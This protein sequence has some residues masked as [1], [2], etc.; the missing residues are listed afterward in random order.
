MQNVNNINT[1]VTSGKGMIKDL[2]D[3]Y[4]GKDVLSHARNAVLNSHQGD[5]FVYGNE[6]SNLECW[7]FPYQFNGS[8]P[9]K[10]K[11]HLIFTTDNTNSEIGIAS[12]LDCSYKTLMND[13]CLNFNLDY[14][15]IGRS[16]E[17]D[18]CS[19]V[20]TFVNNWNPIRRLDI[21]KIPYKYTVADDDCKT[22][23]YTKD[24]DCDS[25]NLFRNISIPKVK[26][27]KTAAGE[28]PNG[29][30]QFL[31][32][33]AIAD[34]KYSDYYA[35]TKPLAIF[36]QSGIGGGMT[37]NISNLDLDF[38]QYELV[39][40]STNKG[41]ST[42]RQVGFFSTSQ[43]TVTITNN[44]FPIEIPLGNLVITKKNY[45]KA[46][47]ISGNSQYLM[48]ADLTQK[49]RLN[50]QLQAFDITSEY[51][52]EQHLADYYKEEGENVGLWR[53]EVYSYWIRFLYPDGSYS[54][55]F[56]IPGR[57]VLSDEKSTVSG[58][59]IF[60]FDS[61]TG[62][63]KPKQVYKYEAYNTAQKMI[64]QN[65]DFVNNSREYGRGF[66]AYHESTE[67][68]PDNKLMFGEDACTPIRH[69]RMPDE[70][71][72]PRYSN[73]KGV[74]YI[75]VLGIR[76]KNIPHPLDENGNPANV[77]GYM[78]LR[79]DRSGG[80]KT[81]EGRGLLTNMRGYTDVSA[82][83]ADDAVEVMYSNYPVNSLKSDA[84]FSGSP[85]LNKNG[86]ES[87]VAPLTKYYNDRFSFYSPHGYFGNKYR[88]GREF[89][90]ESEEVAKVTGNF[91][92]VYKHPKH[93]LM[94]NFTLYF[95]VLTGVVEGLLEQSGKT[96]VIT[97]HMQYDAAGSAVG[98]EIAGVSTS[99]ASIFP[100]TV[101]QK[102]STAYSLL[103]ISKNMNP[104][105]IAKRVIIN[106][107]IVLAAAGA[108]IY[109]SAEFAMNALKIIMGF[110]GYEQYAYQYNSKASFDAQL[111][112]KIDNKRR[113]ALKQPRYITDGLHNIDNKVL[114]NFGKQNSIYVE[115]NKELKEPLTEDD[116][117][118]TMSAFG[119]ASNPQQI[120]SSIGSAY[121]ATSKTKNPSQY[122][123]LDSVRLVKASDDIS[124]DEIGDFY[125]SPVIFGGDC[126]INRFQIMT[127][128]PVFTQDLAG[129]D[130]PDGTEFNY[131]LY[132][133]IAYPR[134][135]ADFTAYQ[136][137][138]II[139]KSPSLGK[140][141]AAKYN[142]DG[143]GNS[144][145]STAWTV[146]GRYFYTSI[147]GVLDFFA[148]ADYNFSLRERKDGDYFYSDESSSLSEIFRADRLKKPEPFNLDPS[149]A[150]LQADQIFGKQ[151]AIDYNPTVDSQCKRRDKNAL[152]Y[153]LPAFKG[154]K[155]DNWQYF[156]PNNYF[157]FDQND[158]GNLT[159]IK[160]L[161]QDRVIFLF[162]KSSP[163]VSFGQDELQTTDGRKV[164]IGDGGLFART[165]REMQ[166]TDVYWGNSKS[167]H[168][169][170]ST[171]F[172]SFYPSFSQG[173]ILNFTG[174]LEEISQEGMHYWCQQ[175]MPIKLY[176][177]Y[178]EYPQIENPFTGAGYFTFFDNSNKTV[179]I[180]KRDFIPKANYNGKIRYDT[181]LESFILGSR[182]IS[183]RDT[184]YFDDISW[185][186]SYSADNKSFVSFHDWHPD[187]VIQ[188][189]NH[190]IT[191]KG[192]KAYKHNERFDSFCNFYGQDFPFDLAYCSTTGKQVHIV[193]SIEYIL[194][195]YKYKN[196]GMDKFHVLNENFD[197]LIVYNSEQ[198]S[199]FLTLVKETS[200]PYVNYSYPKPNDTGLDILFSKVE[201]KYRVNQF[202]DLNRDR[203]QS[204][205]NEYPIWFSDS[206]GYKRILN[207]KVIDLQ[208]PATQRKAFMHYNNF[209]WLSKTVSGSNKFLVKF[210][211]TNLTL[212]S[213]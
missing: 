125:I 136:I 134:F 176:E 34:Q 52:V 50:Y 188:T 73:I 48:I 94:T 116:S 40:V 182:K 107:L 49:P 114:N 159:T 109:L 168:A 118:K 150:K 122:G 53:D 11:K 166:H 187:G 201:Q 212:S 135:W 115:F 145:S 158:Y 92:P 90:I 181:E 33:Y 151:Q 140:L 12:E 126:I 25:L 110:S 27:D 67:L 108:F 183:V 190:F 65:N 38:T 77:V 206:S 66:L 39:L 4:I 17:T 195:V 46:G 18:D 193:N 2:N 139:T 172:G 186:L 198:V 84:F 7:N 78:I 153:S 30:Y 102:T 1:N 62:L 177:Y 138:D 75:N 43:D 162:D 47:I 119:T 103:G 194:E 123:Q 152:I 95:S 149:F 69:H 82:A 8:V 156:L 131:R 26:V 185:T 45:E 51:V 10:D 81:I 111:P 210:F 164:T 169:F 54:E 79:G 127:K 200:S 128:Q 175:Y 85:T 141:P 80:N 35:L 120:V 203:G 170:V 63:E 5:L 211:D 209:F 165:P 96:T 180:T 19:E 31:V 74:M 23:T 9:L 208:K 91:E 14:P 6:P 130:N 207:P 213:R 148:E 60:E 163:Y 57:R 105:E 55:D 178:P 137:G 83:S 58:A 146:Q 113:Y 132:R 44:N 16:K 98:T 86:N 112:V 100:T 15:I 117:R 41:V 71:R 42:A 97:N 121:Y 199:G 87:N 173:R 154:T 196:K 3:S 161:D 192:T 56:N 101:I 179:Y 167:K 64:V 89:I 37:V 174:K 147:N 20:V 191:I 88:M 155:I 142:L 29:M 99:T 144:A 93:K 204:S 184:S 197:K 36:D 157:S 28:L 133:N 143:K 202:N 59:D 160:K 106:A 124:I 68:Y 104:L 76:F 32:A 61:N 129:F 70:S 13:K 72:C 205:G 22:K 24:I 21:N 171:Q 189:E